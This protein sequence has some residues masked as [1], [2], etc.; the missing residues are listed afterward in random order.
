MSASK[1]EAFYVLQIFVL[2]TISK[3]LRATAHD[4]YLFHGFLSPT[5]PLGFGFWAMKSV[6]ARLKT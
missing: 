5:G 1:V 4:K 6:S 2:E 3:T